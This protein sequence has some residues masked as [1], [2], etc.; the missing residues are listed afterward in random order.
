MSVD[1]SSGTTG[2][3]GE[4]ASTWAWTPPKHKCCPETP[5]IRLVSLL[6]GETGYMDND[7]GDPSDAATAMLALYAATDPIDL[8]DTEFDPGTALQCYVVDYR[9]TPTEEAY[10][11]AYAGIGSGIFVAQHYETDLGGGTIRYERSKAAYA[12]GWENAITPWRAIDGTGVLVTHRI[13]TYDGVDTDEGTEVETSVP[14]SASDT[15]AYSD[16]LPIAEPAVDHES[17]ATLIS[18]VPEQECMGD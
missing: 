8:V 10:I 17:Y 18:S 15:E 13:D 5:Q 11:H 14:I 9:S 16:Y 12:V 1:G 6:L 2:Y 7:P 3:P 4:A